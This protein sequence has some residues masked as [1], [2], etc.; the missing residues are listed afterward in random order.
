M[1]SPIK[2]PIKDASKILQETGDRLLQKQLDAAKGFQ[3]TGQIHGKSEIEFLRY[4]QDCRKKALEMAHSEFMA[5][6][7]KT[8]IRPAVSTP[9]ELAEI[10]YNWLINLAQ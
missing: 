10:Y 4:K 5:V 7:E 9:V 3:E 1:T 6:T 8:I 2:S